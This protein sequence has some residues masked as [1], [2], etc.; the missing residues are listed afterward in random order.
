LCEQLVAYGYT[1]DEVEALYESLTIRYERPATPSRYTPDFVL[2]N[3]IVVESK[4]R[5]V[6]ADR[7]KH[8]LVKAQHP[9]IDIRFVF[10]NS[11]TRISKQSQT[12]YAD[13]CQHKGFQYADKYI[14]EAWLDE[15]VNKQSL[16]A[17]K[18][19][20]KEK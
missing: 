13:W 3:G 8:L 1:S 16:A 7:K 20:L 19:L 18:R 10:S 2:R 11:R 6:T 12:T 14:P 9:D 5:F 17:L 4:G 15:P